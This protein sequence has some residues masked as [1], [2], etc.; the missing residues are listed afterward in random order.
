MMLVGSRARARLL[1]PLLYFTLL[2]GIFSEK[3]RVFS[4][5]T[6]VS[7]EKTRVFSEKT[8]FLGSEFVNRIFP[9]KI[10]L[11]IHKLLMLL[12]YVNNNLMFYK[13]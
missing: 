13:L 8:P 6:R 2:Y 4:E 1:S 3:T 5:K 11:A 9:Q 7:T 10:F 12:I